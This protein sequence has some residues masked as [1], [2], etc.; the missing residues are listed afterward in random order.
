M[1]VN[2]RFAGIIIATGDT[3]NYTQINPL[4][5]TGSIPV[6]QRMVDTLY[7][8]GAYPIVIITGQDA[9]EVERYH[10]NSGAV[11]L[12]AEDYKE[13]TMLQMI[14]GGCAYLEGKHKTVVVTSVEF[15]YFQAE[16]VKTLAQSKCTAG[17]SVF[18]NIEGFPVV[19]GN[20]MISL[21]GEVETDDNVL[22]FLKK[23]PELTSVETED[24]GIIC[25]VEDTGRL[26]QVLRQ[27]KERQLRPYMKLEI[28]SEELVFDPR[29]KMLLFLLDETQSMKTSSVHASLSLGMA[30]EILETLERVMGCQMVTRYRDRL[31]GGKDEDRASLNEAGRDFLT[32]YV[33]YERQLVRYANRTF[34]ELFFGREEKETE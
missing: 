17:I 6:L 7:S 30:W 9:W 20:E 25:R 2:S 19:L 32:K 10:A 14:Q 28:G 5:K 4:K 3:T 33:K 15:P 11:F 27:Q 1:K 22:E 18:N 29:L 16:T 31:H 21:V 13:L 24:E 12:R 23:Q 8:A 34:E 26:P